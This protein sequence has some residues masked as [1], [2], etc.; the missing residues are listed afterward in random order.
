MPGRD[1]AHAPARRWCWTLHNPTDADRQR[2]QALRN[3]LTYLIYGNEVCPTTGR[4]HLQGYSEFRDR[5]SLS[6]LKAFLGSESL[7][8]EPAKGTKLSNVDY[9][10]KADTTPYEYGERGGGQ[11]T[12]NDIVSYV[13][14]VREG[15]SVSEILD[16]HPEEYV[17]FHGAYEKIIFAGQPER[18]WQMEVLWFFGP[19]GT[20]KSFEAERICNADGVTSYRKSPAKWWDGYNGEHTVIFDDFRT[21]WSFTFDD[22]LRLCDEY[23]L[24]VEIKGATRRFCS[25]RIIFTC[26]ERWDTLYSGV[27]ECLSQLRRRITETRRFG[28]AFQ[29]IPGTVVMQLPRSE[30]CTDWVV[31]QPH[32]VVPHAH[33]QEQG[34]LN[35]EDLEDLLKILN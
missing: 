14:R 32:A 22:I 16:S 29:R 23:P 18:R 5:K 2:I 15:A 30:T 19:T 17:R 35:D 33:L 34:T 20:G 26:P 6:A 8:A 4:P 25:R 7:H 24:Q 27:G 21:T 11:G 28:V 13:K 1:G 3:P 9:C 12:R 31:P 10:S